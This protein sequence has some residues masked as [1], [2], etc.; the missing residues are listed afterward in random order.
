MLYTITETKGKNPQQEFGG[1]D[2]TMVLHGKDIETY[3]NKRKADRS[4][5]IARSC[6]DKFRRD[7]GDRYAD[8]VIDLTGENFIKLL[9]LYI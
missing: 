2:T 1:Y 7:R 3:G 5:P 9:Y 6:S 8:K 4:K